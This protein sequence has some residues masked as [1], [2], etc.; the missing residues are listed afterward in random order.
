MACSTYSLVYQDHAGGRT[1][2]ANLTSYR[3]AS[4]LLRRPFRE[5][6][7]KS[8]SSL[9]FRSDKC[10][11]NDNNFPVLFSYQTSAT[12]TIGRPRADSGQ[13]PLVLNILVDPALYRSFAAGDL[14]LH[15]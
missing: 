6:S 13:L 2:Q 14:I 7:L 5:P 15:I 11:A 8:F 4:G 10:S 9:A 12:A 3:S 1:Y